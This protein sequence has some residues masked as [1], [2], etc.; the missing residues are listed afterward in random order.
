MHNRLKEYRESQNKTPKQ[1]AQAMGVSESSYY[2]VEGGQREPT[3]RFIRKFKEAFKVSVD[4][5]FF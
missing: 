4:E 3:Y 1:M 2:K 5:I